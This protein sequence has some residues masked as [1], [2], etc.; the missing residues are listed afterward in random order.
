MSVENNLSESYNK[1][2]EILNDFKAHNTNQKDINDGFH[3]I[4]AIVEEIKNQTSQSMSETLEISKNLDKSIKESISESKLSSTETAK[5]VGSSKEVF[6]E[7]VSKM[8][9]A[10]RNANE[11]DTLLI[12]KLRDEVK[13]MSKELADIK[14]LLSGLDSFVKASRSEK[15]ALKKKA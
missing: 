15:R 6:A 12:D 1:L 9:A 8:E 10:I 14:K 7:L 13:D 5:L 3:K 2:T 4:L 11:R